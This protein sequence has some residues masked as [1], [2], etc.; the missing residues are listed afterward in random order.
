LT[1]K[2]HSFTPGPISRLHDRSEIDL[3]QDRAPLEDDED[4]A[5]GPTHEYYTSEK[6]LGKLYRSID[7]R[8]IWYSDIRTAVS[9]RGISF[10][11]SFLRWASQKCKSLGAVTWTHRE[12]EARRIQSAYEDAMRAAMTNFSEHPVQPLSEL[13]VFTG[14]IVNKTGV[15]TRR[16]RDQSHK[17]KDEFE[18]ISTWITKQIRLD[19]GSVSTG[20][21][22]ELDNL[23]RCL[24]CVN[25]AV[26]L[27][28]QQ[29]TPRPARRSRKAGELHSFR[30]VAASALMREV[31]E[32]EQ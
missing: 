4:D 5:D 17:L 7:E 14:H 23:E 28:V 27:D 30:L 9:K 2:T 11:D 15:Q 3:E 10:W 20:Y 26:P 16:Q 19:S 21:V 29:D 24:A 25:V 6:V 12:E 8:K 18:R 1:K 32:L 13:E 31:D 22:A